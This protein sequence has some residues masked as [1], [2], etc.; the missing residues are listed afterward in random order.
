MK[1][2]FY[3]ITVA[4]VFIYLAIASSVNKMQPGSFNHGHMVEEKSDK[5]NY[6][7]KN[8]GTKIYGA[9]IFYKSGL[10]TKNEVHVDEERFKISD[11]IGY[12]SGSK[13]YGRHKTDYIPRIIHGKINVYILTVNES[14]VIR[15]NGHTRTV[16]TTRIYS[17][18]Q[19]GDLGEMIS[20]KNQED[21]KKLLS[22][23]PKSVE[24]V[25]LSNSKLRKAIKQNR[26]YLNEVFDI[27]NNG[28]K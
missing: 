15:E 19:R 10:L 25:D 2:H 6:I 1:R 18:A 22:D 8:D 3:S 24:M 12:R 23:C 14:E 21:M 26:N 4:V 28:C 20:F 7:L 27:Y 5:G 11:V 16:H 9:K 17:Y 13:F